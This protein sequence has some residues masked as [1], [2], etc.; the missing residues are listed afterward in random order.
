MLGLKMFQFLHLKIEVK[1]W[2]ILT[3]FSRQKYQFFAPNFRVSKIWI[4]KILK[5]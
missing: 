4:Y 5:L 3:Y 1:N 2:M